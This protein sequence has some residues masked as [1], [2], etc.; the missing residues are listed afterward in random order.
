MC[1]RVVMLEHPSILPPRMSIKNSSDNIVNRT[2]DLLACSAVPQPTAPPRDLTDILHYINTTQMV[3]DLS[4]NYR[5]VL[6]KLQRRS[7]G[8]LAE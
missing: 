5:L 2:R 1:G 4:D 7:Y 8:L 6:S 3:L